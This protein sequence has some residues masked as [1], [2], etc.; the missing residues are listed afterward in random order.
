MFKLDRMIMGNG[1]FLMLFIMLTWEM[2][3]TSL[4]LGENLDKYWD[5][6]FWKLEAEL[7]ESFWEFSRMDFS[8]MQMDKSDML[9]V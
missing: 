1:L 6:F 9:K 3:G 5:E 4:G 7:N 8:S 2:F